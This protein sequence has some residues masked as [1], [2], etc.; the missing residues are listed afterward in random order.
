MESFRNL[1]QESSPSEGFAIVDANTIIFG[2]NLASGGL[3]FYHHRGSAVSIPTPGDGTVTTAK[4]A[5]GAVTT[6]K[7]ADET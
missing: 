3:C 6:A 5:N 2:S 4:I 7:I 1:I